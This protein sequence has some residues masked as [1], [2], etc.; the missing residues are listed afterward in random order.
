APRNGASRRAR[1]SRSRRSR[2]AAKPAERRRRS[3]SRRRDEG[4][5]GRERQ[6]PAARGHEDRSSSPSADLGAKLAKAGVDPMAVLEA[7]CEIESKAEKAPSKLADSL[8]GFQV[9]PVLPTPGCPAARSPSHHTHGDCLNPAPSRE[10]DQ[11]GDA[12]L[13]HALVVVV[14]VTGASRSDAMSDPL[15]AL[16]WP[17]GAVLASR[18]GDS[19]KH[20][21]SVQSLGA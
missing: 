14:T 7:A 9:T 17:P 20:H 11:V 15:G 21:H 19:G 4:R 5:R 8:Q 2:R 16:A 1:R 18:W 6:D 10:G 13:F 3:H 12:L